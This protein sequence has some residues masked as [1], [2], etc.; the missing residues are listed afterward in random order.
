MIHEKGENW[1]DLPTHIKRGRCVIK[2][3][4]GN[5]FIDR[6]IPDFTKDRYYIDR[7]LATEEDWIRLIRSSVEIDITPSDVG[8]TTATFLYHEILVYV[9][10]LGFR[11]G[12][13]NDRHKNVSFRNIW[14]LGEIE[15]L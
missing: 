6:E 4:E 14:E 5:W 8:P 7:H 2:D 13:G 10:T 9:I 11:L 15:G 12:I 1:N 3:D